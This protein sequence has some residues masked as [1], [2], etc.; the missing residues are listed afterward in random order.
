VQYGGRYGERATQKQSREKEAEG[1]QEQDKS[2]Y[3]GV[4]V[5]SDTVS[6]NVNKAVRR[7]EDLMRAEPDDARNLAAP[8]WSATDRA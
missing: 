8:V 7:Q 6:A 1:G 2:L 5:G 3:T 4:A